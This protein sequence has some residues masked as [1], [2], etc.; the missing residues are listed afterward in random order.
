MSTT[1]PTPCPRGR[2]CCRSP[3]VRGARRRTGPRGACSK[4]RTTR[5]NCQLGLQFANISRMIADAAS[6]DAVAGCDSSTR[7]PSVGLGGALRRAWVGYQHRLD[8][9]M[10]AA[11][12]GEGKFPD[13]RV[14]RLCSG[15]AGSTISAVG[16]EPASPARAPAKWSGTCAIV[17]TL[18][19]PTRP[20]AKGKSRWSSP[21]GGSTTCVYNEHRLG[22]SRTS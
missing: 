15:Q 3:N 21:P 7:P 8:T 19:L 12:F 11:G 18:R 1:R 6:S 16:R 13:G 5:P 2:S 10:A 20:P 17:A 9:A 4:Y 14:L 22:R